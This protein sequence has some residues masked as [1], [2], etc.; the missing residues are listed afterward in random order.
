MSRLEF[1]PDFLW[2]AATA[3]YQIEGGARTGGKGESVWDRFSHTPG[4]IAG[5]D[6]GD[7]ACDSYHRFPEDIDLLKSM[8]LS[9]YRFSIAW[10]RIQPE[11]KG[12]INRHGIDYYRSLMEALLEA[13]IRP[14]PTL[15]HW[16]LPQALEDRGGWPE[17]DTAWRF[18]D[19]AAITL[20]ALG[21]LASDWVIFNEPNIFTVLGYVLG[22]HAPGHHSVEE[23]LRA[24]HTVNLAQGEAMR[25]MRAESSGL[26]IGTAFNMSPCEPA[27]DREE[28][29]EASERWH[30]FVN[31]WFLEPA[32]YGR[33]PNAFLK[34]V[35]EEMMGIQDG[36]SEIMLAPLDFIGINLYTRTLVEEDLNDEYGIGA[37]PVG[38][39]DGRG[40]PLTDFG[41]EVWPVALRDMVLRITRDYNQPV[42]EITENGCAYGDRPDAGGQ[43]CDSR[44]I[45]FHR[46]FLKALHEA[47]EEGADVR[48]YHAWS[49]LDN[50]E[51]AEGYAQR[52]G[53]TWVDFRTGD[54]TLKDSG[55]WYRQVARENGFET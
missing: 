34:G 3:A 29:E 51:W 1:P 2:G 55:G 21:D 49:L 5:G 6:T 41:W 54:R 8:N 14:L 38:P 46:S 11:G 26:R 47:I 37:K 52:F 48:S 35:P 16:D 39:Q 13:D 33:Y 42:I 31:L 44:R 15:Y 10:T 25:A 12:P 20:R 23:G 45:E 40:G 27:G 4:R 30:R 28:D 32:L 7:V 53:L 24:T 18:A 17:R 19:Y 9:S 36:D 50:F 43:I 22:I